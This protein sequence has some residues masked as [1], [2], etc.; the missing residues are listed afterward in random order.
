MSTLIHDI[1]DGAADDARVAIRFGIELI[2]HWSA[3]FVFICA[4]MAPGEGMDRWQLY[5]LG[6]SSWVSIEISGRYMAMFFTG[7]F[8]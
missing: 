2:L 8:F 1:L 7:R 3:A 5:C 6:F 4:F